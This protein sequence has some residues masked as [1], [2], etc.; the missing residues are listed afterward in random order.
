MLKSLV[1]DCGM[2]V[3]YMDV[4]G[5]T[6]DGKGIRPD[7]EAVVVM[8]GFTTDGRYVKLTEKYTGQKVVWFFDVPYGQYYVECYFTDPRRLSM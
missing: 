6:I 5:N 1:D 7:G 3:R 2:D 4:L 8:Y